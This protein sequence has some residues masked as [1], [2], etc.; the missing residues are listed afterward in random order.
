[1]AALPLPPALVPAPIPRAPKVQDRPARAY[2]HRPPAPPIAPTL[3]DV[4]EAHDFE[5]ALKK[6]KQV[7]PAS[8]ITAHDIVEAA[9]YTH[10]ITAR[11]AGAL[12]AF[13]LNHFHRLPT[14]VGKCT[15]SLPL[16]CCAPDG[17]VA[18]APPWGLAIYNAVTA[19]QGQMTAQQGQMTAQ[20]GQMTAL[21]GQMTALQGQMTAL[22]DQVTTL[23]ARTFNVQA[24]RADDVIQWPHG[25]VPLPAIPN[26]VEELRLLGF[27][28]CGALLTYYGLPL[29]GTVAAR[30]CAL[31]RHIGLPGGSL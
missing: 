27:G 29:G 23:Q 12:T 4:A 18:G 8:P 30:R 19:L 1:M 16:F 20:Q 7:H 15:I 11:V 17:A 10:R 6:Q 21:Q 9:V 3:A 5:R 14:R 31:A 28:P 22:Q 24:E 25:A 26:T 2:I 13:H